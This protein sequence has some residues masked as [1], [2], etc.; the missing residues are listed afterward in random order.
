LAHVVGSTAKVHGICIGADKLGHFF[1]E[2]FGY[3]RIMTAGGGTSADAQNVGHGLEMGIQG[4]ATTGVFSNADLAANLAGSKFYADL[5]AAPSTLKFAVK[6]YITDKWN[7]QSNPSF[8]ESGLADIVWNNLLTGLWA[9][10]LIP[11]GAPPVSKG[12][13]FD[14]SAKST[15]VTGTYGSHAGAAAPF[16]GTVKNGVV[17]QT[18]T[19]VAGFQIDGTPVSAAPVSGVSIDFDWDEGTDAGKGHLETAG[20]QE[21]KGTWGKGALR[22]GGGVLSLKKV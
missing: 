3:F 8:Y 4:L 14:L 6:N 7:E 18:T 11:A 2:G 10:L 13:K 20:E 19:G 22:T 21:L 5:M 12:V 15:G 16:K 1:E 9:G 17:T